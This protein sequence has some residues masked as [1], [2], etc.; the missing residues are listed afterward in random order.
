MWEFAAGESLFSFSR[1]HEG[2]GSHV[3][4]CSFLS[5]REHIRRHR[6]LLIWLIFTSPDI[7]CFNLIADIVYI[8]TLL[9][10]R[11]LLDQVR[12]SLSIS[13]SI[14]R[15]DHSSMLLCTASAWSSGPSRGFWPLMLVKRPSSKMPW[16]FIWSLGFVCFPFPLPCLC[17]RGLWADF[18]VI[19]FQVRFYGRWL[20]PL[21]SPR[22]QRRSRSFRLTCY[23]PTRS[24]FFWLHPYDRPWR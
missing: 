1:Y 8:W 21:E 5:F 20:Q 19:D 2:I 18:F 3:S 14:H 4:L 9:N 6:V 24:S 16:A 17:Q 13:S 23:H 12:L 15:P 11:R 22:S 10:S 7:D